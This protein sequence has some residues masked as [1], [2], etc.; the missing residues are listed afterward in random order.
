MISSE[1]TNSEIFY[2]GKMKP[3][4]SKSDSLNGTIN[5]CKVYK[6]IL[7]RI[8]INCG[9]KACE[10]HVSACYRQG[11]CKLPLTVLNF[12]GVVIMLTALI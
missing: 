4:D 5:K 6:S 2:S 7:G 3:G 1:P 12:R 9:Q 10:I 11:H 8:L